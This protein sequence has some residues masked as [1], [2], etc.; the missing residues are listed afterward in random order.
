[1]VANN[2]ISKSI[3]N[4]FDQSKYRFSGNCHGFVKGRSIVTNCSFHVN[5]K[6]ILKLDLKNFFH[7]INKE[8]VLKVFYNL[9]FTDQSAR[10]L[11]E[12]CTLDNH[13]PQGAPTS[14]FL[15]NLACKMLD[16]RLYRLSEKTKID[17][18]RYADDLVFSGEKIKK[19]F[20]KHVENIIGEEGF[21]I[22]F[23]KLFW[24]NNYRAQKVT[25]LFVNDKVSYGRKN[26]KALSAMIHNCCLGDIV[27]QKFKANNEYKLKIKDMRRHLYGTVAFLKSIDP[28]KAKKLKA[29]LD[30][31]PLFKWKAYESKEKLNNKKDLFIDLIMCIRNINN[32]FETPL[33]EGRVE[34]LVDL[35]TD[36]KDKSTFNM[37]CIDLSNFFDKIKTPLIG[38]EIDKDHFPLNNLKEWFNEK[39][40]PGNELLKIFFNIKTF[41]NN[42]TRHKNLKEISKLLKYYE[43]TLSN[44]NFEEL[45][46]SLVKQL[47]NSLKRM[48]GIFK[49]EEI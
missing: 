3:L 26:Y 40:Y 7:S 44:V 41:S 4:Y 38:K 21:K 1:M 45:T 10:Y 36:I 25:G 34:D 18:T 8:D 22:N 31:I 14:P 47:I 42:L 6:I 46:I 39:D 32:L 37:V 43:R 15:S 28:Q 2:R 11:A 5:K 17:Y 23:K 9:G 12:L 27:E 16:K 35:T 49:K 24:A 30:S 19:S 48:E 13:L 20:Y 33:L 29:K